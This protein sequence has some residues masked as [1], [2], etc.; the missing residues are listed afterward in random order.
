VTAL[1][2]VLVV[3]LTALLTW[4]LF[5]LS[6]ATRTIADLR[7]RTTAGAARPM[8]TGLHAGTRAPS[9]AGLAEDHVRGARHLVVFVDP[10]CEACD[11]LVPDLIASAS[12]RSLPHTVLVSVG[13]PS[14]H[15]STWRAAA[16]RSEL[17]VERDRSVSDAYL[18]DVTPTAFLVDEGGVIVASTPVAT[19]DDVRRIVADSRGVRVAPGTEVVG[20]AT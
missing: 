1:P 9:I 15:P 16:A 13:E 5:A 7:A 6:G 17:V 2:W 8:S 3:V 19:I 12:D 20:D 10:D 14:E 4:L 11:R 18:V